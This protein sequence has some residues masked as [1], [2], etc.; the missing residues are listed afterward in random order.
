MFKKWHS[1]DEEINKL[2]NNVSHL[3]DNCLKK[4]EPKDL[5]IVQKRMKSFLNNALFW[6]S[7]DNRERFYYDLKD[8]ANWLCDFIAEKERQSWD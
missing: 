6:M 3:V 4:L 8:F 2:V 5:I 7:K 1:D